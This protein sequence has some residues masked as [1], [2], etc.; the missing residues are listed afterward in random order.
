MGWGFE[1]PR[2]DHHPTKAVVVRFSALVRFLVAFHHGP[3]SIRHSPLTGSLSTRPHIASCS[4]LARMHAR[5]NNGSA[6]DT[7][8]DKRIPAS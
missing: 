8:P 3:V 7:L 5:R 6:Q 4:T 2:M 1:Q